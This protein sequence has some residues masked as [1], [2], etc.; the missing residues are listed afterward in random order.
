MEML[1]SWSSRFIQ[2]WIPNSLGYFKQQLC[3]WYSYGYFTISLNLWSWERVGFPQV[4]DLAM[5]TFPLLYV[6]ILIQQLQVCL[7]WQ[8]CSLK[9]SFHGNKPLIARVF[10]NVVSERRGQHKFLPLFPGRFSSMKNYCYITSKSQ[11][12]TI[13]ITWGCF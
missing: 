7:P 8:I 2:V 6:F 5:N 11:Y 9:L 3:L 1:P 12:P 13:H 4:S 10:L